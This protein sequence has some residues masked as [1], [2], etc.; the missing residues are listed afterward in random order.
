M[1]RSSSRPARSRARASTSGSSG[2]RTSV[3]GRTGRRQASSCRARCS[4]FSRR[5]SGSAAA[6]S[7]AALK[8]A[9]A[10]AF[11]SSTLLGARQLLAPVRPAAAALLGRDRAVVLAAAAVVGV[12]PGPGVAHLQ[13]LARHVGAHEV[14]LGEVAGE[15]LLEGR[16]AA[17]RLLDRARTPTAA[18]ARTCRAAPAA[19]PAR[20][21]RRCRA[22]G[23]RAGRGRRGRASSRRPSRRRCCPRSARPNPS[24]GGRGQGRLGPC[25]PRARCPETGSIFLDARGGDR[26]LRVSWHAEAGLVVLSLWRENVCA[27]SFRLAVDEV[28]DLIEM[29]RSGLDRAYDV[30]R[31]GWPD[32][33]RPGRLTPADRRRPRAPDPSLVDAPERRP[34]ARRHARARRPALVD[35][36][37]AQSRA[38][39]RFADSVRAVDPIRN[40]YAPGAGQRP[41]E[42]AGRDE[43]LRAFDVVL[44][45]VAHGPPRAQPGAH[46]AARRRQDRAAQRAALGRRTPRLGHRQ[47]RG[48]PRPGP[49]PAAVQRAAPGGPRARPPATRTSVDHVLGVIRSFAQRDAGA[50]RQA[51]RPV[52]PRHRRPGGARAAPTPATSR[53]TS[54][55]CSPT[56]AASPPTSARASRSSSTRCRTSAP[57]TSPRC[58]PPA[59]RSASP[60]CR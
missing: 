14:A 52:E 19:R 3:G 25:P 21:G 38:D 36:P 45:R 7:Q 48:P 22:R 40:P 28:P 20:R 34:V 39:P 26:A 12:A 23:G 9:A 59:T 6:R 24:R 15:R 18:A 32:R 16:A 31:P 29:L 5:Y 55:S 49:A 8:I 17:G 46:R 35:T 4:F 1:A 54:S 27:G 44:E 2:T 42:L 53:S 10:A 47:A 57:T 58:A 41:P 56:S 13:E 37:I 33:R 51:A 60:G 43:Q 50:E 11:S 30:A